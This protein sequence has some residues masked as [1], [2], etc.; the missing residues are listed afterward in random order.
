MVPRIDPE[1]VENPRLLIT[2][3]PTEVVIVWPHL[4]RREAR[5][6]IREET[7]EKPHRSWRQLYLLQPCTEI[8]NETAAS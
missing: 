5:D 2:S 1:I 7:I 8:W 4:L 3:Q 6:E